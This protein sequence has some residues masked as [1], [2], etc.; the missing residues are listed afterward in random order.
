MMARLTPSSRAIEETVCY[1]AGPADR[2]R[3]DLLGSHAR[4]PPKARAAG[5]DGVQALAGALDDQLA[6]DYLD[7]AVGA[8]DAL[9]FLVLP[10][11]DC[12]HCGHW[13][14]PFD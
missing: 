4:R 13:R 5:T 2:G 9:G 8:S 6:Y 7:N 10:G 1:P 12:E 11:A 3:D 14:A